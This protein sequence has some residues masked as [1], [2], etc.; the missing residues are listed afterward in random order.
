MPY[1]PLDLISWGKMSQA[2]A[3]HD[4]AKRTATTGASVDE[5][6]DI[7]LYI[8]RKD[9]EYLYDQDPNSEL[10]FI[11]GNYF[12]TLMGI[13]L[14]RAQQASGSGGSISPLNPE[15]SIPDD[16]DFIVDGSTL[17]PTGGS[18]VYLNGTNGNPDLRGYNVDFARGGQTQY[19]T[20]QPGDA[21]YYSWNRVT[22]L[23]Q[24]LPL[25]G[26][27]AQAGE[28]FRIMPD[29]GGYT[30][31]FAP[32]TQYPIVINS[33]NFEPDGVTYNDSRIVGDQLMI[34]ITGYNGE[35]QFAPTSFIYTAT[36]IEIV[37]SGFDAANFGNIIIQK[38][39]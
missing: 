17:I 26:G 33:A 35:Y 18:S 23:F 7:K 12:L 28:S 14:F 36:G 32:A 4:Y 3:R 6:L 22:G 11:V 15:V 34:F 20:Q 19:T 2:M 29:T 8:T 16:I 10:L 5:D 39:N 21:F 31:S 30:T 37:I 25:S 27:E 38:I 9:M 24:L 13:Y 1:A